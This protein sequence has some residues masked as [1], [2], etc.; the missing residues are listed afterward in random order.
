MPHNTFD[1]TLE[2]KIVLPVLVS[3]LQGVPYVD[4]KVKET[5]WSYRIIVSVRYKV[6][7]L[8]DSIKCIY[9]S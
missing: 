4:T 5:N 9:I 8:S 7:M 1:E 6:I 3:T 2:K